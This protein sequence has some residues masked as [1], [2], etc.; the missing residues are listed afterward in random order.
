VDE[1]GKPVLGMATSKTVTLDRKGGM[2]QEILLHEGTHAAT[3][4]VIVQYEKDPSKLSEIQRVA[5]RELIAL[6]KAIQSDPRITSVSAKGSLSEFVAEVFSNKNLQDQ[7]RDKKWRL[8]DAWKGF[9]SIIMRMLGTLDAA[10]TFVL[11]YYFG[12]S[13]GS[14]RKDEVIHNLK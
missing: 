4:R 9:K 2:S 3:E 14:A 5:M 1:N 11:A 10:L 6:H 8:S 13:A 12:S 7:M